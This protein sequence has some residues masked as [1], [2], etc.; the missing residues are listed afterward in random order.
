MREVNTL[1]DQVTWDSRKQ[2]RQGPQAG[3]GEF[4]PPLLRAPSGRPRELSG[5]LS[6]AG[7]KGEFGREAQ[8]A[9]PVWA[10]AYG[11]SRAARP[12][13]Q[14]LCGPAQPTWYY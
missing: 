11:G 1:V 5:L 2:G 7:G 9:G 13:W 8:D 10:A 14:V 6:P 4:V 12:G 3:S